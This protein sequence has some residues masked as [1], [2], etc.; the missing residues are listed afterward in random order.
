MFT[1]CSLCLL[2]LQALL[3]ALK[4][5]QAQDKITRLQQVASGMLETYA[6]AQAGCEQLTEHYETSK[7]V[8]VLY[9]R[10]FEVYAWPK[11]LVVWGRNIMFW[12]LQ[13]L[14][15]SWEHAVTCVCSC[16]WDTVS[17]KSRLCLEQP[18]LGGVGSGSGSVLQTSALPAG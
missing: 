16:C 15:D 12:Q 2:L 3:Q 13:L 18:A 1:L 7:Q 10:C 8:I 17:N 9:M 6:A 5:A 11:R 4:L 14:S